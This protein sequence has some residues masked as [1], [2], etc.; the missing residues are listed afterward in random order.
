MASYG[1]TSQLYEVQGGFLQEAYLVG[2]VDD[3][4]GNGGLA[5]SLTA[6]KLGLWKGNLLNQ[7]GERRLNGILDLLYIPCTL[8]QLKSINLPPIFLTTKCKLVSIL[9]DN[10]TI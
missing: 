2:L 1:L 7:S 3:A 6:W 10:F 4:A 9:Q 8:Y 5:V